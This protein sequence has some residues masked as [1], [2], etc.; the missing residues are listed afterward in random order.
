MKD[1]QGTWRGRWWCFKNPICPQHSGG[2]RSGLSVGGAVFWT[3]K[4]LTSCRSR[5]PAV[6]LPLFEAGLQIH[7]MEP[8]NRIPV[9]PKPKSYTQS[10]QPSDLRIPSLVAFSGG[11]SAPK[12]DVQEVHGPPVPPLLAGCCPVAEPPLASCLL[13]GFT[14]P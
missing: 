2:V 7:P 8:E 4:A 5:C 14:H 1:L 12:K 9:S 3:E 10:P 6:I 13:Q 11:F